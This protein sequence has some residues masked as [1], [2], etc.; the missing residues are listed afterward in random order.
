MSLRGETGVDKG[1][2]DHWRNTS[3]HLIIIT[4]EYFRSRKL[5]VNILHASVMFGKE[6]FSEVTGKVFS[7]LLPVEA[8][9]FLLDATPHPVEAYIK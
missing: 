1:M 5:K 2:R 8:K 3:S 6:V 4:A 9:C 7:S